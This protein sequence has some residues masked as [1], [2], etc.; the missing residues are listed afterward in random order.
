MTLTK[1]I[2]PSQFP[3]SF[4]IVHDAEHRHGDAN[5]LWF[6]DTLGIK[7]AMLTCTV[8]LDSAGQAIGVA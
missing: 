5:C 1:Q 2:H 7:P 6:P 4:L 8:S 3:M